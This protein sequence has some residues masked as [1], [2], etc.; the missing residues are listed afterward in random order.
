MCLPYYRPSLMAPL[1][2]NRE[3]KK[4]IKPVLKS[5]SHCRLWTVN[6]LQMLNFHS[7]LLTVREVSSSKSPNAKSNPRSIQHPWVHISPGVR[8]LFLCRG[9]EAERAHTKIRGCSPSCGMPARW[10]GV[11]GK[12]RFHKTYSS[13]L[14][15]ILCSQEDQREA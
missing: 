5:G 7:H 14:L 10:L 11:L 2:Q 8:G 9:G 13:R 12:P 6:L 4:K 1:F 15:L 3:K